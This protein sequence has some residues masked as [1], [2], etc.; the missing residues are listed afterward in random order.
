[1][2]K[3]LLI[4]L[5]E[6]DRI[7]LMI[8]VEDDKSKF[9]IPQ[10]F[11]DERTTLVKHISDTRKEQL[12]EE[13]KTFEACLLFMEET[14]TY[15]NTF[16]KNQDVNKFEENY[17]KKYFIQSF[18]DLLIGGRTF[19]KILSSY[20]YYSKIKEKKEKVEEEKDEKTQKQSDNPNQQKINKSNVA[21]LIYQGES[22]H[23]L[24]ETIS[25]FKGLKIIPIILINCKKHFQ[26]LFQEDD[27]YKDYFN[28]YIKYSFSTDHS[29]F[30]EKQDENGKFEYYFSFF[31]QLDTLQLIRWIY[32][33]ILSFIDPEY[34]VI[35]KSDFILKFRIT[36]LFSLFCQEQTI[37]G[38]QLGEQLLVEDESLKQLSYYIQIPKIIS[39]PSIMHLQMESYFKLDGRILFPII[40]S[41]KNKYWSAGTKFNFTYVNVNTTKIIRIASLKQAGINFKYQPIT[42]KDINRSFR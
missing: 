24:N 36:D 11:S 17:E 22:E 29:F 16:E 10:P 25:Y 8:L 21:I 18:S 38:I 7:P 41:L 3:Y 12:K 26:Q 34:V 15:L 19:K 42:R 4:E 37:F 1:M 20:N 5:Q 27:I 13:I 39:Q 32:L 35:L 14:T 31:M 2:F 40:K 30:L 33:G 6:D 28:M 23:D 9:Q